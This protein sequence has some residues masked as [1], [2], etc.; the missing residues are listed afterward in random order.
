MTLAAEVRKQ[1]C[2]RKSHLPAAPTCVL[3]KK[4]ENRRILE[5]FPAGYSGLRNE[6]RYAYNLTH[7]V[8]T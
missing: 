4:S 5:R 3:L 1:S 6:R 7:N 8:S 2:R